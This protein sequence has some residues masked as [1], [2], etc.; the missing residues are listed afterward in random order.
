MSE[1]TILILLFGGG[2]LVLVAELFLPSF[3]VLSVLG[4][5][6]LIFGVARV[7]SVFGR[8][9]GIAAIAASVVLLPT[10]AYAG[11]KF[12]ARTPLGRRIAPPN[13]VLTSS[14]T[15]VPVEKLSALVGTDGQSLS[16]LRPVGVCDF[17][18][19]RVSCMAQFGL[20]ESKR[21]VKGV[22]ITG[23]NLVVVEVE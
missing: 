23:G 21:R 10:L 7:F 20:I 15:S 1:V 13:P 19:Q 2:V 5:F 16:V 3:G 14:D 22:A 12:W 8:G 17:G 9:P 18:G 11:A 6:L 4:V